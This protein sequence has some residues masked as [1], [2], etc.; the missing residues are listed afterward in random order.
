VEAIAGDLVERVRRRAND[1][2]ARTDAPPST[3]GKTVTV[4]PLS[5]GGLDLAALLRGQRD[6]RPGPESSTLRPPPSEAALVSAEARLGF[7]L[8]PPLRQLYAEVGDGGFGPGG[9]L[10]SLKVVV[11][12]YLEL[13]ADAPGSKGQTWPAK[14]LPFTATDP[15]HDCIDVESGAIVFWDEEALADGD[16]DAIWK[17]SFK[18]D[19]T[20]LAA[21]LERWVGAPTPEEKM[22][23]MME[24]GMRSSLKASLDHWRAK[25]PA[26]RAAFGLPEVGWERTL[27][28]HLG[29]DLD[30]L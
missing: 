2:D 6:P 17:R 16:S 4:G 20:S 8:P 10:L 7:A 25:S 22:R 21:W 28:G 23:S 24:N 18:P 12:R 11:E 30:G 3:R 13:V 1:P 15:G 19:A 14:L 9:G 26:E 29:I 27:F 5:I